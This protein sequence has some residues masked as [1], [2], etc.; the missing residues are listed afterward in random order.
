M[1][2]SQQMSKI[3]SLFKRVLA[4]IKSPSG[5]FSGSVD[6]DDRYYARMGWLVVLVGFGGFV[7]WA[8]FAPIDRG[9]AA[10]GTVI[11]DG[12]RKVVQPTENGI[13]DEILVKNGDQV[14]AGQVLIR[15]N[16]LDAE[17]MVKGTQEQIIGLKAR[18][19]ALEAS[20]ASRKLELGYMAEQI[21]SLRTL[22][23]EGYVAKNRL[24]DLERS[25]AQTQ[26]LL[27]RD[28]G[29]LE[30]NRR[31]LSDLEGKLP[32]YEFDLKNT[33]IRSPAKGSVVNLDVFTRGQVVQMG[34]KLL[35]VV[36]KDQPMVIDAEVPVNLIDKVHAGLHA[37]VLFTA[38]NAR[39][40]PKVP[41]LVT[42]VPQ[43][44]SESKQQPGQFYYQVRLELLP[45][46]VERL[47]HEEIRAGMPVQVFIITGERSMMNY[48]FR[49]LLDRASTALGE[50]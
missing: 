45:E 15:L 27:Q 37:K 30:A 22:V 25:Q 32:A 1:S 11:T 40:T 10:N 48:L 2:G 28:E 6:V 18:I 33:E 47:K 34:Q 13:V 23:K 4:W 19:A 24:L 49:P 31:Q 21:S 12:Q 50:Q 46:A 14:D 42:V 35:E 16:N 9:V 36:P 20:I 8:T 26:G 39:T 3:Q 41:A 7:L 17:A 29:E 38:L 43:D 44:R 5:L